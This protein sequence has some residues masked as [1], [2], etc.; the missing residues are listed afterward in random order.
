MSRK[1]AEIETSVAGAVLFGILS[2][3]LWYYSENVLCAFD[4][5]FGPIAAIGLMGFLIMRLA[6]A[7]FILIV[8]FFLLRGVFIHFKRSEEWYTKRE[9]ENVSKSQRE[10]KITLLRAEFH[11][12]QLG[13][14]QFPSALPEEKVFLNVCRIF[15]EQG[16]KFAKNPT[17]A[18]AD[19]LADSVKQIEEKSNKIVLGLEE[20]RLLNSSIMNHARAAMRYVDEI[21]P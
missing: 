19:F 21:K 4:S 14:E 20:N 9:R 6:S 12:I 16:E 1:K 10:S 17:P 8:I 2:I 5:D 11:L 13:C 15:V 3:P 7:T 18:A